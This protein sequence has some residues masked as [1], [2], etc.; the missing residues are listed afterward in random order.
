MGPLVD[1][2]DPSPVPPTKVKPLMIEPAEPVWNSSVPFVGISGIR[3]DSLAMRP[4]AATVA[5]APSSARLLVRTT[6]SVYVPAQTMIVSPDTA[7]V[8][9]APT[10]E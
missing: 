4:Q 5:W 10:V 2:M 3:I 1:L 8:T 6:F 7:A 9:A